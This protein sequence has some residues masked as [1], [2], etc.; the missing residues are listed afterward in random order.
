[1]S[2]EIYR[3]RVI[4]VKINELADDLGFSFDVFV[5]HHQGD[6]IAVTKLLPAKGVFATHEEA[7]EAGLLMGRRYVDERVI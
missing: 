4:E 1:M 2:R 6:E 5:E 3:S 7:N